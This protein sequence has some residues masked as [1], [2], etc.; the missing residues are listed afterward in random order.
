MIIGLVQY[1]EAIPG[2]KWQRVGDR[3]RSTDP[4]VPVGL[5]KLGEWTRENVEP[6]CQW[7]FGETAWYAKVEGW[8]LDFNMGTIA[9][10]W[11]Q[12]RWRRIGDQLHLETYENGFFQN[13]TVVTVREWSS[14]ET[15]NFCQDKTHMDIQEAI[16]SG[17][18]RRNLSSNDAAV[19]KWH[20]G[21]MRYSETEI[22]SDKWEVEEVEVSITKNQLA[23]AVLNVCEPM[24]GGYCGPSSPQVMVEQIAKKLGLE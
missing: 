13:Q 6:M 19:K 5:T 16:K 22:L 7:A 11:K 1:N 8:N 12:S 24:F 18:K 21:F 10:E 3:L 17:K 23:S 4:I 20:R 2:S 15:V 14:S 9:T